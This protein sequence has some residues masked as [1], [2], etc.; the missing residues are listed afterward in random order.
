[1]EF[2]IQFKNLFHKGSANPIL[3]NL[4]TQ[5]FNILAFREECNAKR[6]FLPIL[7]RKKCAHVIKI[8]LLGPSNNCQDFFSSSEQ[9]EV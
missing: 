3:N 5:I 8:S 1:M 4:Y 7:N 2:A 9:D 6:I